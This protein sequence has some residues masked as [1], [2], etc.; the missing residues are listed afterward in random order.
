MKDFRNDLTPHIDHT[1]TL[2]LCRDHP[3]MRAHK[4][5]YQDQLEGN[6][7]THQVSL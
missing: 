6:L 1:S 7:P 2:C 5:T 4:V 3:F